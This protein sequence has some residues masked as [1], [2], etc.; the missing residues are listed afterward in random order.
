MDG[1][2]HRDCANVAPLADTIKFPLRQR[3]TLPTDIGRGQKSAE[4]LFAG[5]HV[6]ISR[7]GAVCG[8]SPDLDH[9]VWRI[10]TRPWRRSSPSTT[11]CSSDPATGGSRKS[12]PRRA[13][14]SRPRAARSSEPRRGRHR[15]LHP[16]HAA[17][18]TGVSR[19]GT[20]LWHTREASDVSGVSTDGK[21]LLFGLGREHVEVVTSGPAS[22]SGSSGRR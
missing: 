3:G 4:A 16:P 22:E 9:E 2:T 11:T 12:T 1:L 10:P 13:P 8:Y 14:R 18:L 21:V 19:D 17:G 6:V 15:C 20:A 5:G 7:A